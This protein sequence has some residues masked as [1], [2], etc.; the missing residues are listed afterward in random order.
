MADSESV[1]AQPHPSRR[2]LRALDAFNFCLADLQTG[3]GPYLATFLAQVRNFGPAQIGI[4]TA[5]GGLATVLVQTPAGAIIDRTPHKRLLL[6]SAAFV[7]AAGAIA[8]VGVGSFPLIIAIQILVGGAFAFLPPG[9]GALSLG[10]VGGKALPKRQGL[11]Q[12]F[13]SGGNVTFAVASAVV[14]KIVSLAATIYAVAFFGL[15]AALSALGIRERDIDHDRARGATPRG[16]AAA[17]TPGMREIF[18]DSRV[19]IFTAIVFLFHLSNASM[20]V[21]FGELLPQK[22]A[23]GPAGYLSAGIIAAQILML[24]VAILAAR[25]ADRLGRKPIFAFGIGVLAARGVLFSFATHDPLALVAVQALDGLGAGIFNVVW[26]LVAADV[27]RGKGRFNL[28]QGIFATAQGLGGALSQLVS[29][30]VAKAFGFPVAFVTLAGIA[31]IA[32]ALELV[33][34]PETRRD[35]PDAAGGIAGAAA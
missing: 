21:L 11:N 25:F 17:R 32:L 27:S 14:G 2:S 33:A 23:L 31:G 22:S 18:A 4:I 9:I 3:I 35:E 19:A 7:G 1:A 29:G 16:S 24:G 28:T 26:V 10:L 30:F 5:A 12:A 8:L 6:A 34:M 15:L 20:L 13:N